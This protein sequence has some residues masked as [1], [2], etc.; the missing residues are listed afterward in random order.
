MQ[1]SVE[2]TSSIERRLT[3]GVPAQEVDSEVEKRLKQ[4]ASRARLNGFRPGKAPMSVVK[5]RF[6]EGVRQEVISDMMR[7][8]YIKALSEEKLNP[9]GLPRFE[10]KE[11]GEGKDLEFVATVEVYPEITLA[12]FSDLEFTRESAE[13]TEK[14]VDNMIE[15]LRKQQTTWQQVGRAAQDGDQLT[16]SYVG[17]LD[18]EPFQGG[19]ADNAR[20]VLGSGRMIPGFEEGLVGAAAG[21]ERDLDLTFPEDYHAEELKGKATQFKVHVIKVEEPVLP[22]VNDEFFAAFG[23]SEGGEEAFRAEVKRN[24]E[25]E[26][27]QA[28]SAKLK[29]QIVD[30]LLEKNQ[31][32]VPKALVTT[33]ID[34]LREDAVRQFGGM[35]MDPK[36]LPAELFQ[37]QAERRVKT[38]LIFA[39]IAK[40]D[41]IRPTAEQVD[42]KIQ[43][44]ASTYQEPERVVEWYSNNREQRSGIEAVVL[45]DLIIEKILGQ[46]KVTDQSVS[47]E[48]AVKSAQRA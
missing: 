18:G 31:F 43:E 37:E 39:E 21:E 25:R 27:K 3:I 12:D 20:I 4:T 34:R 7:D 46:A 11:L 19:S 23:V 28:L 38:G 41:E 9:A 30:A 40:A 14:D 5:K 6:G 48:D 44:I 24:M 36:Q 13:V 32:D 10:P 22:E 47:Y 16:V 26:V 42:A 33:E 2:T 17:T 45:E 15:N 8:A 35:N 1:V 29:Q